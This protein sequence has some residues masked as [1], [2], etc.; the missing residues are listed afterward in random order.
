MITKILTKEDEQEYFGLIDRVEGK[1]QN[2]DWWLP[3]NDDEKET[4]FDQNKNILY[5]IIEDG[6]LVGVIAL[7]IDKNVFSN[8][9]SHWIGKK[10]VMVAKIGRAAVDER[11]RGRGFAKILNDLVVTEAKMRN[12]KNLIAIAHPD[13]KV[14]EKALTGMGME[15][16]TTFINKDGYLRRLYFMKI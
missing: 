3:I 14:S 8:I 10:P 11:Y 15:V 1:L 5:G 4:L 16:N 7:T 6:A 9:M 12:Y 13:N 2:K